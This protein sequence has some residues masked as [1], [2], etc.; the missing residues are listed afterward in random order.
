MPRKRVKSTLTKAEI[1]AKRK[2]GF[3][4]SITAGIAKAPSDREK[5]WWGK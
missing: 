4:K 5:R 3:Q 2:A 1:N